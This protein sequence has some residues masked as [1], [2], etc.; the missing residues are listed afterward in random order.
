[1]NTYLD[2]IADAVT[3]LKQ[4][5]VIAYPTEAVWGLGCDPHNERAVQKLL[6]LKN[7]PV[8]K[9]LIQVA[10]S[11]TQLDTLLSH[12]GKNHIDTL[13]HS[14][15]GPN[16]WLIPDPQEWS[17]AWVR[18]RFDSV[19]VRVSDH[20]LVRQLS[21][22][23]GGPLVSTSANPAGAEPALTAQQVHAYFDATLDGILLGDVGHL[24]T[25][26]QIRDLIS[27]EIIRAN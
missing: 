10:A 17:P 15:P 6:Q 18:G 2:N 19:A 21:Q 5:G 14:W 8:E 12:L 26:T 20:P 25:P 9:G 7:R 27:G 13:S 24:T 4:G 16:T 22:A 3:V 23:F 1:M 11:M